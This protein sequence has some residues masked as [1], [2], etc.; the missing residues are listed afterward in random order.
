MRDPATSSSDAPGLAATQVASPPAP[1][2]NPRV[3]TPP[4]G[5]RAINPVIATRHESVAPPVRAVSPPA[6]AAAES[7]GFTS[8]SAPPT[9]GVVAAGTAVRAA[10]STGFTAVS[11]APPGRSPSPGFPVAQPG[12]DGTVNDFAHDGPAEEVSREQTMDLASGSMMG[13]YEIIRELGRGGM[14]QVFMARD[15]KLGRV[16]AVKFLTRTGEAFNK[17]FLVE[18]QATARCTH[19]NI[20]V[21]HE[22]ST[23]NGHPYMVLEFLE[24]DTLS[25][26]IK[27][28]ALS[29]ERAVEIMVPVVRALQRAHQFGIVHRDLKPDNIFITASGVVKVLDFGVAKLFGEEE[30]PPDAFAPDS[31]TPM[32]VPMLGQVRN[33]YETLSTG[34]RIVG[35]LPFMSPEQF[36]AAVV[37]EQTD[38]WAVG[39][40]LFRLI[41]GEHPLPNVNDAGLFFQVR[42]LETP[43]R[44][45]GTVAPHASDHVIKLVDKCLRKRKSERYANAEAL[46]VDLEGLL[47]NRRGRRLA[48]D[49]CPYPGLLAFDEA[50]ADRYFGR[51]REVARAVTLLRDHSLLAIVGPSGAGKS[52]FVR[53]GLIPEL[54]ASGANWERVVIRPGRDPLG[55]LAPVVELC[56]GMPT[57]A[58]ELAAK[59]RS[60]PGY[61][62]KVMRQYAQMKSTRILLMI[63]QFEE[64]Y[65]QTQDPKE[66]EIVASVLT[67]IGDDA[68]SPLRLVISFRSDFLHR[69]A[70]APT[71]ADAVMRGLLLLG[72]PEG[73]ALREAIV[74]PAQKADY[75]FESEAMVDEILRELKASSAP[76]PLMQFCLSTLWNHRDRG[77]HILPYA[78]FRE[79]GGVAG[80]LAGHADRL[81]SSLSQ[82]AQR[83]ARGIFQRL[84]SS[85]GTRAIVEVGELTGASTDAAEVKHVLGALIEARLLVLHEDT[86]VVEIVHE[87]LVTQWPMLRR[88]MEEGRED[89]QFLEQVRGAARQWESSGKNEGLLWRGDT[90]VEAIKIAERLG[91]KLSQ[92]ERAYIEAV[93]RL[94]QRSGRRKKILATVGLAAAGVVAVVF[95]GL[96]VAAQKAKADA[97][98]A[99]TSAEKAAEVAK[100]AE[101]LAQMEKGNAQKAAAEAKAQLEENV[102]L[103]GQL[104]G[105]EKEL[106]AQL[107]ATTL[108]LKQAEEA[109]GVA[110]T[111]LSTA[112]KEKAKAIAATQ[113]AIKA[114]QNLAAENAKLKKQLDKVGSF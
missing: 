63:D 77:Q 50:D 44:G 104:Q 81:V 29:V 85:D 7:S 84:V 91:A 43:M 93:V 45:L 64:L 94:S 37:D 60:E 18:A 13:Q 14:G 82:G 47:P 107:E 2:A 68:A 11:M 20:V 1:A 36:G 86:N 105:K 88:W 61:V 114:R 108:A 96:F 65:T 75:A 22:A 5:S 24:G 78:A 49:E 109:K 87:S 38:I 113:E 73:D 4:L 57:Q 27:G 15:T 32:P 59:L 42:E 35:T 103:G 8:I 98:S 46:L 69:I 58:S 41:S 3:T 97:E 79:M 28:R 30:D 112:E 99:L 19:E 62:G 72:A 21:I 26:I 111:A 83:T 56:T 89:T 74:A 39:V 12:G 102:R 101:A 53:A 25:K 95:M 55:A 80:A 23:F 67:G 76:Y 10:E 31:L 66:R 54:R 40:I 6:L 34:G 33:F 17:R 52:S 106:A 9:K 90:A 16:V 92:R 100:K 70:E 71:F 48:A 51:E 110:Q